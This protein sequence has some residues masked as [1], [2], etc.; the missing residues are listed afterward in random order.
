MNTS[1]YIPYEC[2]SPNIIVNDQLQDYP[3]LYG[4]GFFC[5]FPPYNAVFYATARHCVVDILD[6]ESNNH[7]KIPI[8]IESNRAVTFECALCCPADDDEDIEDVAVFVVSRRE[9]NEHDYQTVFDRAIEL[10]NQDDVDY[11]LSVG[12]EIRERLRTVGYPIHDHPN[13]LTEIDYDSGQLTIQPRGFHGTLAYDGELPNHYILTGVNWREGE[14]RGF[15]GSPVIALVPE[16]S[17]PSSS[18]EVIKI[19]VGIIVMASSNIARFLNINIVT[20]II[21]AYLANQI[22]YG[23]I[24]E[25]PE[26]VG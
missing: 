18:S 13:C 6:E 14:Y 19:P 8:S 17:T 7:L 11:M 9:M 15:S 3:G 21:S 2:A 16:T 24:D 4:T 12:V 22:E 25:P 10:K 26:Q 23:L 20:N 5:R 1:E